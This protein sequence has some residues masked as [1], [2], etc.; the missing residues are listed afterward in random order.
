MP[1]LCGGFT[2]LV[3]FA[4]LTWVQLGFIASGGGLII[5]SVTAHSA[6]TAVAAIA[7]SRSIRE[8]RRKFRAVAAALIAAVLMLGAS[9]SLYVLLAYSFREVFASTGGLIF[10]VGIGYILAELAAG[11]LEPT[12]SQYARPLALGTLALTLTLIWFL[13]RAS[14]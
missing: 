5:L 8:P 12:W 1:L 3:V 6:G 13:T 4:A 7:A 11:R 9:A 2:V 10:C 14:L